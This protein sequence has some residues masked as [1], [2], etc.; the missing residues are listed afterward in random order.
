MEVQVLGSRLDNFMD[1]N[2][3]PD[4]EGYLGMES[5]VRKALK[6]IIC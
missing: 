6:G 2:F 3:N 1:R 5:D 4:V